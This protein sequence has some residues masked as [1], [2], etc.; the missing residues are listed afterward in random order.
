[1]TCSKSSKS[2][3]AADR[4]SSLPSSRSRRGTRSLAIPPT[5]T[6]FSTASCTMR[7]AS[8]SPERASGASAA[9][10]SKRLDPKPQ[11]V[12][13]FLGQ[14]ARRP[15]RDHL[16]TGGRHHPGIPG[17]NH[18]VTDGRLHR[19]L[20]NEDQ[21]IAGL[22]EVALE[23]SVKLTALGMRRRNCNPLVKTASANGPPDAGLLAHRWDAGKTIRTWEGGD[24]GF[25]GVGFSPIYVTITLR[26]LTSG[27][28]R[29]PPN[30][31]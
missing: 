31:A 16:V 5:P 3:M 27:L 28:E 23:R 13:N 20:R 11:Q 17:R 12:K 8:N 6:P 1:M 26:L 21:R 4:R 9:G 2:V 25:G 18:P 19:S 7:I 24:A 29:T 10:S 22:A 14:Q 30:P 15:G